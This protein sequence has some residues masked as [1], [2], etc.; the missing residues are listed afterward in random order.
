MKIDAIKTVGGGRSVP[1]SRLPPGVA[2]VLHEV[3]TDRAL[4]MAY[5]LSEYVARVIESRCGEVLRPSSIA[6]AQVLVDMT[7][8]SEGRQIVYAIGQDIDDVRNALRA[9]IRKYVRVIHTGRECM[10]YGC[11]GH[12]TVPS[13]DGDLLVPLVC[14]G[15]GH[16]V[17]YQAWRE[18]PIVSEPWISPRE[19][20]RRLSIQYDAVR[21]RA[22]RERW[23]R[24]GKGRE[25]EYASE[26]VA[27]S[28]AKEHA[29]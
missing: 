28:K 19:A 2:E 9:V 24:R 20:A 5:D 1:G 10:D 17:S 6:G 22:S 7:Y 21:K 27:H 23:R 15:C 14:D 16:T 13:E 26:S 11:D 25:V 29:A 4:T 18:W 8:D 3:D 12:Y